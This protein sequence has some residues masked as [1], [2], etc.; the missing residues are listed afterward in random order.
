MARMSRG[1]EQGRNPCFATGSLVGSSC[2]PLCVLVEDAQWLD[3]TT[4]EL[5]N[6]VIDRLVDHRVLLLITLR[7][8][9]TPPWGRRAHLTHLAMN[10]LSAR[11]CAGLIVGL[12]RGKTLPLGSPASDHCQGRRR[13]VVR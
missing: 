10:R 12:A 4:Q 1:R 6:L 9:F 11:A 3:P 2:Q 5:L 7:P 13:T 8:E